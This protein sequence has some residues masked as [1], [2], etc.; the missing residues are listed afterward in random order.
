VRCISEHY[1]RFAGRSEREVQLAT[2][3]LRRRHQRHAQQFTLTARTLAEF[4]VSLEAEEV[5]LGQRRRDAALREVLGHHQ[6]LAVVTGSDG[7]LA[8]SAESMS[9]AGAAVVPESGHS[10]AALVLYGDY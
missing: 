3:E 9:A 10:H 4:L 8:V 6:P 1:A 7:A 2:L 5:L